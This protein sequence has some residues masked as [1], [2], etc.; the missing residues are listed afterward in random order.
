MDSFGSLTPGWLL[1]LIAVGLFVW[2]WKSIFKPL[3]WLYTRLIPAKLFDVSQ[4]VREG[5]S[6]EFK[7]KQDRDMRGRET[8]MVHFHTVDIQTHDSPI[9]IKKVW[10]CTVSGEEF[11]AWRQGQFLETDEKVRIEGQ[12]IRSFYIYASYKKEPDTIS[13][14]HVQHH[15]KVKVIHLLSPLSRLKLALG[16]GG[17]P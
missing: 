9:T 8:S 10:V 1:S 7:A 4:E 17:K 13:T 5:A 2:N 14:V 12:S 11:K 6:A 15:A 3:K 16:L